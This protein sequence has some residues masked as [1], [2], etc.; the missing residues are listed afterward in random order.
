[1]KKISNNPYRRPEHWRNIFLL[2]TF[3]LAVNAGFLAATYLTGT[4]RPWINL[5][6]S[7]ALVLFAFRWTAAGWAAGLIFLTIDALSTLSQLFP[8]PRLSDLVYLLSFTSLSSS[9]HRLLLGLAGT[10]LA[11]KLMTMSAMGKRI[12]PL[13]SLITFNTLIIFAFLMTKAGNNES[14]APTYRDLNTPII[15]SQTSAFIS[16]RSSSFLDQFDGDDDIFR[17]APAGATR[18]WLDEPQSILADRLLLVVVESWGVSELPELNEGLLSPLRAIA[19]ESFQTGNINFNGLTIS[20][21]LRELCK[22][23]PLHLNLRDIQSGFEN[24]LPNKLQDAGYTTGAMHGATSLMYDRRHW[25]PRVGFQETTF[26]EDRIWPRRCYSFPG[27]CDLDMLPVLEDFFSKPGKRFMYWLT[28]NTHAPYD[29][30]DLRGPA[31]DCTALNLPEETETC[32]LI[33]LQADFFAGLAEQLR[34]ES[35]RDVDVII[36][37]DHAPNMLNLKEREENFRSGSVPWVRFKTPAQ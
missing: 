17:S 9:E 25:Y 30:R 19:S 8:Y 29:L 28:L 32:R 20:G 18:A 27:A 6:Y 36:V 24:C 1:M 31:A 4:S 12:T 5:D 11:C 21:E 13:S 10:A 2:T 15:F 14:N 35:L 16:M 37:G 26:F 33:R 7:L 34:H 3:I 23:A 22:I